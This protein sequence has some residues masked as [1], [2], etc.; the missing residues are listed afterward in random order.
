[1]L[2]RV[3]P[4]RV[5]VVSAAHGIAVEPKGWKPAIVDLP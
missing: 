1:V 3:T 2:L 5:E 4:S